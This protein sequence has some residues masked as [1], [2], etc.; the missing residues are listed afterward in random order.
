VRRLIE[1]FPDY[2]QEK[3][4]GIDRSPAVD[5]SREYSSY[6]PSV[7]LT[8]NQMNSDSSQT[9]HFKSSAQIGSFAKEVTESAI[10]NSLRKNWLLF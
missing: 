6:P 5:Y 4:P 9:T 8:I 2:S 1:D 10:G 3:A 7:S